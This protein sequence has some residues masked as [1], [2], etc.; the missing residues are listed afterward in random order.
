MSMAEKTEWLGLWRQ[1]EGLYSGYT[2]RKED[3]PKYARLIVRTN[4]YYKRDSG[5]PKYVYCFAN[6]DAAKAITVEIEAAEYRDI[7]ESKEIVDKIEE[8]KEVLRE[9]H[10]N[11]YG[12]PKLP[13]EEAEIA[14]YLMKRA[15]AII[16][17]MTGEKWDFSWRSF[18]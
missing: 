10:E 7:Q 2:L 16:E 14:Q 12:R 4:K 9:S 5:R 11:A 6:G 13:S 15:I 18:G 17:D 1:R 3:I 8:L